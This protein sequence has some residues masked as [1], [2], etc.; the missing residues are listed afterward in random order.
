MIPPSA[1]LSVRAH[2]GHHL[3]HLGLEDLPDRRTIHEGLALDELRELARAAGGPPLDDVRQLA[4]EELDGRRVGGT[5]RLAI[6]QLLGQRL[7]VR[8]TRDATPCTDRALAS[9]LRRGGVPRTLGGGESAIH[10]SGVSRAPSSSAISMHRYER[11]AGLSSGRAAATAEGALELL[12][13]L[14]RI[15]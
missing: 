2:L 10:A 12:P 7:G 6:V 11:A 8:R 1:P 4:I 3:G 15:Q 14:Q 5:L 13:Q 9:S